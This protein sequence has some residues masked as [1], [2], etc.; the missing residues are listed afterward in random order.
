MNLNKSKKIFSQAKEIIPSQSQT[1]SK[2]WTQYPFG[3]SPI[4]SL[5]ANGQYIWDVDNNK[6]I[7]W[8]MA[9]GPLILGHNY[10][11]L[12]DGLKSQLDRGIA[13]SLPNKLEV[14]VADQL[15][16]WFNCFDKVRFGKNGSDVTSAAVRAARAITSREHILSSG[17]HGWQDWFIG[18]TSRS[19]GVP[20]NV[21][22]LIHTFE[23]NNI[24]SLE[25]LL[26]KHKGKVAAIIMEPVGLIKPEKNFLRKVRE[27]ATK[28]KCLLI[29][30]ECWTCFR[31]HEKG[32]IGIYNVIPDMLCIGKALGNGIP[33]SAVLGKKRVMKVFED[34]FFSFTFGGDVL[35]LSAA[36]NVLKI[37]KKES[38]IKHIEEIGTSLIKGINDLIELFDLN[39]YISI[40]GYPG[41]NALFFVNDNHN[42][43][44]LKS[45]LQETSIRNGV[46]SAAWHAPSFSHNL[47]DVEYTLD[48]YEKAFKKIKV[49]LENNSLR[50]TLKGEIV[51]EV[52][53]KI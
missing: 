48:T 24:S 51:K 9:L 21:K 26:R 28:N 45:I 47:K 7:D 33:I 52:F 16:N 42:G 5:R 43:L 40:K 29:F 25:I 1:F 17:Y 44:L 13:F 18:S 4:F 31:L 41:R 37:I 35:G 32:S 12:N 10:K 22:K 34:I 46:L 20:K 14:V 19:K 36:N 49:G 50:K 15:I 11:A 30:D 23:Y 6:Y 8:P 27:L 38:V 39:K 53:R 2:N 3:T